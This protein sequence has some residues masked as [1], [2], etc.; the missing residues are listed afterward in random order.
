MHLSSKEQVQ[1]LHFGGAQDAQHLKCLPCTQNTSS[2]ELVEHSA[3][4]NKHISIAEYVLAVD[5]AQLHMLEHLIARTNDTCQT[6]LH[7]EACQ[8]S[9]TLQ[10]AE[11][12]TASGH[13]CFG[14]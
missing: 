4:V 1:Q 2:L 12:Q 6:H 3:S 13:D 9:D 14:L 7:A 11:V 5:S 8:C 10:R